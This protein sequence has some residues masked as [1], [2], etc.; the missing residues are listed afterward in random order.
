CTGDEI[1]QVTLAWK[2][3]PSGA[4]PE[5]AA[6]MTR[7]DDKRYWSQMPLAQDDV[8]NYQARIKFTDGSEMTLPDN[9]GDQYYSIYSGITVPLYC[10]TFDVDPF[11]VGWTTGTA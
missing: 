1:S 10:T 3:G 6:L 5:G 7:V 4:L 9:L 2:S 11:T 8:T